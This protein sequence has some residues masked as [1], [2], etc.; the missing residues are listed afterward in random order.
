MPPHPSAQLNPSVRQRMDS[1]GA[2]TSI[3]FHASRCIP[4][5]FVC[6]EDWVHVESQPCKNGLKHGLKMSH[7]QNEPC[8]K[9]QAHVFWFQDAF[10][11]YRSLFFP[12]STSPAPQ[13]LDAGLVVD[14]FAAWL[15]RSVGLKL[16]MTCDWGPLAF[17]FGFMSNHRR[18]LL[19]WLSIKLCCHLDDSLK[20][21]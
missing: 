20:S 8:K 11:R 21:T 10:V 5:S 18:P 16:G 4:R 3:L 19:R 13:A 1:A 14:I 9:P 7:P 6:K 17:S 12:H 2:P 15:V